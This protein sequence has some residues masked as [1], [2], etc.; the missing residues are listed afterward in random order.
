MPTE[1]SDIS[2][3]FEFRDYHFRKEAWEDYQAWAGRAMEILR[4]HFE[5]GA[6]PQ[7]VAALNESGFEA[8]RFFVAGPGW[9][10][11]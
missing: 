8:Q 4:D 1:D 6:R 3:V 9:P 2:P 10:E 5:R 7:L 11:E